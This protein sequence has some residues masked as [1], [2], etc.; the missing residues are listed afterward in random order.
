MFDPTEGLQAL[1]LCL[2]W[3]FLG[4]EEAAVPVVM[5]GHRTSWFRA[6]RALKRIPDHC[7]R[8]DRVH[9]LDLKLGACRLKRDSMGVFDVGF[10][11]CWVSGRSQLEAAMHLPVLPSLAIRCSGSR[12][13]LVWL[14]RERTGLAIELNRRLSYAVG[15]VQKESDPEKLWIPVPGSYERLGRRTPSRVD[16]S[17]VSLEDFTAGEVVSGLREVPDRNA[18][19]NR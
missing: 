5:D 8:M 17:R 18:W 11:H 2:C 15:G 10:L 1:L 16:V 9:S 7:E 3:P 12:R 14:L 19:R 6:S 13:L 4:Y